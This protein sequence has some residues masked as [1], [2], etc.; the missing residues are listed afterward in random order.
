MRLKCLDKGERGI[1]ELAVD[2]A[3]RQ[4]SIAVR[5]WT[6][7]TW[8][9]YRTPSTRRVARIARNGSAEKI[10]KRDLDAPGL[11]LSVDLSGPPPGQRKPE[12]AALRDPE[13]TAYPYK[14]VPNW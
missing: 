4:N 3:S 6:I 7:R 12:R 2:S 10:L 1:S 9:G 11:L 5:F 14:S 8:R 13:W